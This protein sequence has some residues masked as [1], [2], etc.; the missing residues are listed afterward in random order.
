MPGML[1]AQGKTTI[2]ISI[3]AQDLLQQGAWQPL[4]VTAREQASSD[5]TNT[6]MIYLADLAANVLGDHSGA[7][8][9][10]Y[11]FPFSDPKAMKELVGW[12]RKLL[13][14]DP[15]NPNLLVLNGS[16]HSPKADESIDQLTKY[17][18][19]AA[20]IAPKN[21]YLY[22]AL[23]SAYGEQGKYSIAVG[24][25]E[26]SIAIRPTSGAHTNLG[27]A[28]L[29]QGKD[30]MAL[31]HLKTAVNLD[32]RDASA[33]FNLG[34]YY[35]EHSRLGEAKLALEKAITFAPKNLDARWNLGG[36]YFNSGQQSKATEQLK[37]II[38]IAPDSK[39]GHQAA[40]MLRQLG[41]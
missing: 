21:A 32:G 23:G 27:V 14:D 5:P 35:A 16:L 26:K 8:L 37:K 36:V 34:S 10:R 1:E 2:E 4:L 20:S 30:S 18:E 25:L 22:E 24:T 28:L 33:W 9:T 13:D 6:Q 12:A 40:Q 11:D 19:Q 15:T 17:F 3:A 38:S 41:E 29:K 7:S 31:K 39:M